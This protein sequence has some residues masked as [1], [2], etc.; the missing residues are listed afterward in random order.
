MSYPLWLSTPKRYALKKLPQAVRLMMLGAVLVVPAAA[1]L[2][3]GAAFA[4]GEAGK[5][6]F[7]I[8]AGQ[9]SQALMAFGSAAGVSISYDPALASQQ[10]TRGLRGQFSVDEGLSRLL[11][12]SGLQASREASGSYVVMPPASGS[13]VMTLG[14]TN[15]SAEGLGATTENSGS[16]TTGATSTATKLPL[17]LRETPQSVSV[18]TRQLMDDQHLSTLN[19]VMAF[20]PGISI[21]HRDSERFDFNSR[22]FTIQN[23]QYDGIPSQ[24]ANESQQYVGAISDMAIYDRVEVIRGATGLMSGAGT[25]SATI[26]LVRK[27][28]TKDFQGYVSG[29]AGAWDRYRS[30]VDVS[31]PLTETGNVRGRF[32]AAYQK[33]NSF[34]DWYGQEKRV[35]YGALDIDLNDSTTLR[36]SLDYQNNDANGS[37]YG[38]IPLFFSNGKQTNFSRSFNPASRSSYMD[39]TSYN[40]TTMLD[41]KLDNDWSL[42]TAYSHQYSYRKG[43][44][45]SAS[46]G[47]P[48]PATGQGTGV[49]IYRLDSYQTQ[50]TLDTYASGPFNLGGRE[51]ELVVGASASRTHLNFPNYASHNDD[52][53]YGSANIF[54]WNGNEY[55]RRQYFKD[56]GTVTTLQQTGLYGALRLKP[57][58]PL[59]IILGTRLSWWN[60]E[61]E[62]SDYLKGTKATDKTKKTGVVTPYVG[63]VYELNDTYS[64]YASYT[65]IFLPQTFYKTGSGGSL[66]PLEGDNY[67]IGLKGEF[68]N[69][70]LNAS[71]AV[72]DIEQKN[73]PE[74]AGVDSAGRAVYKAISGTNTRGVETEI[75]GEVASGWNVFGGYTYRESHD[76]DGG[77]VQTNQPINL[78]KF[79]T[80]YRLPGAWSKLTVGGNV[81]WQSEMYASSQIN[82]TGPYYKATQDPFAVVGLLA[83]YK[84][85]EHLT[86]GLNVNNLF[87]QKYYDG[88]GTFNSGSYGEPR[89]AMVN[90]K[91]IF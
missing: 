77:R 43:Q 49:F 34:I 30:E 75:S 25:P 59:T 9:L 67:E 84:V 81:T 65:S 69:G 56:G 74:Q 57:F 31:G 17:S 6:A 35:M 16:Y 19:E 4:Q 2:M 36:T 21:N 13:A 33:Q 38:H 53:D 51:H 48:D 39:N 23:F 58:D 83:K 91:W 28:P 15:I 44:G 50:D 27:R 46:G 55:G 5:V 68:F 24:V 60:Q 11:S 41:H 8:P 12:G 89:N 52:G 32:V 66:A 63:V 45:A 78:F 70:A 88:M 82:Y 73:T 90:A 64:A 18:V 10:T 79:G 3:P 85:D 47:Y 7:A 37:S 86:V 29:E 42:K 14:A 62:V 22:G 80:T 76:K 72:F 20:T 54:N 71:I 40:F 26:N 87:D 1:T 61:D